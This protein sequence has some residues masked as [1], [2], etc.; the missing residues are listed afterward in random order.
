M[1]KNCRAIREAG[2]LFKWLMQP[3]VKWPSIVFVV[4]KSEQ[5]AVAVS[6][7]GSSGLGGF[8]NLGVA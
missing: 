6:M 3:P 2:R 7:V 5:T 1:E 8:L 4:E